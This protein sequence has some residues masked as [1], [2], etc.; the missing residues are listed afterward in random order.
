MVEIALLGLLTVTLISAL[1]WRMALLL[2]VAVALLQDPLRKIAP[3]Q[4]LYYNG[5][6]GIVFAAAFIGASMSGLRLGPNVIHGWRQDL[7]VPFLLFCTL[8]AFQAIHSYIRWDNPYLPL[9]G[10]IFYLAPITAITFSHQLA[11]RIGTAGI[12]R[13]MWFYVICLVP[14]LVGIYLESSGIRA[15]FLGE[16]G[17]GQIIYDVGAAT[18]ANAGL[19]RA[20]EVAAWHVGTTAI[21][22]FM[23]LNGRKLSIPKT[24]LVTVA[25]VFLV[26]VGLLTGRRKMLV[27][28][29]V[30]AS[31]Y[32]FLVSWF[33]RGRAKLAVVVG[34]IGVLAFGTVLASFSPDPG[35]M[36]VDAVSTPSAKDTKFDAWQ[37]RGLTVFADI[38][39]RFR[40]LGYV[41][42]IDVVYKFGW[43]GAGLGAGGQGSQY[44][45]GGMQ[46]FGGAIE[47]GLGKITLDVG[48]PGMVIFLWLLVT[49]ARLVWF[50]L[51][52]LS[53][54]SKKH[55]N[56][57]FGLVAFLI[58]NLA[59]FS[60]ATQ[61][62]GDVYILLT[63]GWSIGI[64]LALPAVAASELGV[65]PA[66]QTVAPTLRRN[67]GRSEPGMTANLAK[68][69]IAQRVHIRKFDA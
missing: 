16:V 15:P 36:S 42:V 69:N 51:K 27:Q 66:A 31:A 8:L 19:F 62:F 65:V 43:W 39:D 35:E 47:G 37:A 63:M 68:P 50:R 56:L 40:I 33:V 64:L 52:V 45:G 58:S 29:V 30:F 2:C 48:V 4:P 59:A 10:G 57:A 11:V 21:F 17:V 60:V 49:F 23:V 13:W 46:K 18:K 26:S 25:V 54:T 38:P 34:L 32:F 28:V 55:A 20:A 53:L 61:V 9:I 14:W 67:L 12:M 1:K 6:V 7:N 44:F 5:F 24:A 3:G 41:P 22:L